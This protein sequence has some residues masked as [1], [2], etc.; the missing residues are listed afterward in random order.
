MAETDLDLMFRTDEEDPSSK[1][2]KEKRRQDESIKAKGSSSILVIED[3]CN[4]ED[5]DAENDGGPETP[6]GVDNIQMEEA[7][8]EEEA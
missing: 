3:S 7:V 2:S 5:E 6:I 8:V 1:A 4:D